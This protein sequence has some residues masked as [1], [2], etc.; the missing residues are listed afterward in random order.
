MSDKRLNRYE[1][2]VIDS[3]TDK[4]VHSCKHAILAATPWQAVQV[5]SYQYDW[6]SV[7]DGAWKLRAVAIKEAT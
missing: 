2:L 4:V 1:I 6:D 7:S 5:F 3:E